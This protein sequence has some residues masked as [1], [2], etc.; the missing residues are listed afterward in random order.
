M[1]VALAGPVAEM[2]HTGD[3]FHP[4]FVA[5]WAADW[6]AAWASAALLAADEVKRI[7]YLEQVSLQLHRQLSRDDHWA[8]LAALV[9]HLLAHGRLQ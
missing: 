2:I 9:D 6:Q 4:G 1:Q 3:P 7:R 8:A 5:E